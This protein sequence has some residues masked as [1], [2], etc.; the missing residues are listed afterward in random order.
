MVPTDRIDGIGG[1][2]FDTR[3]Q[4]QSEL[5]R[6]AAQLQT[7]VEAY[8]ECPEELDEYL[9]QATSCPVGVDTTIREIYRLVKRCMYADNGWLRSDGDAWEAL[10]NQKDDFSSFYRAA[11][12]SL[13]VYKEVLQAYRLINCSRSRPRRGDLHHIRQ[14]KHAHVQERDLC[15]EAI[16]DFHGKFVGMLTIL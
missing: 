8:E 14:D 11:L 6:L 7:T 2:D 9:V 15:I 13:E 12:R 5:C 10:N 1:S 3:H 16:S 4:L